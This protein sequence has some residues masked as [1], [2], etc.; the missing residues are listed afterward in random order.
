MRADL[1]EAQRLLRRFDSSD[2]IR[3]DKENLR[4]IYSLIA[5]ARALARRDV[6]PAAGLAR[7]ARLLAEEL[8]SP[9]PD[10]S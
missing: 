2:L 1:E 7:K 4:A 8:T 9:R 3:A 6:A 5:Q 10:Y